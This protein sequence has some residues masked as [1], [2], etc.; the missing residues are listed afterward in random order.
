MAKLTEVSSRTS[1]LSTEGSESSKGSENN[2]IRASLLRV[3]DGTASPTNFEVR[4]RCPFCAE[5]TF[6][7]DRFCQECGSV[8]P[9]FADET[10]SIFEKAKEF[11]S[12]KKQLASAILALSIFGGLA[13]YGIFTSLS[14]PGEV[15]K[16][17]QENRLN[18]AV[19]LSE[20]LYVARFGSLSGK[21]AELYSV[22]FHRRAQIFA[23]N[24]N[25]KAALVDLARVLP[26]Y[27]QKAD[28][29]RLSQSYFTSMMSNKDIPGDKASSKVLS[30]GT[31]ADA[32]LQGKQKLLD[33]SAAQS[34]TSSKKNLSNPVSAINED[35]SAQAAAGKTDAAAGDTSDDDD[36]RE[37]KEMAH[38]NNMLAE[39]FSKKKQN[40]S[41]Q[42][43]S[44][45]LK[46][47]PSFNEWIQSGRSEF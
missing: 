37:E 29:D 27:S 8:Q 7:G 33:S 36:A 9:A 23:T 31:A 44:E 35:S 13:F 39:Y 14:L 20:Q 38:Y 16:S 12:T 47:P 22:A 21:D 28:V 26:A 6:L 42:A 17:L 32:T 18:D 34:Q 19:R 15:E 4:L 46:E 24:N 30:P 41:V 5:E 2:E 11:L 25:T 43:S 40:D 3:S 45:K 10:L 1:T